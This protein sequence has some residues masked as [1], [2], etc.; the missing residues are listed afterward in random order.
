MRATAL[1]SIDAGLSTGN[2]LIA[3]ETITGGIVDVVVV[4]VGASVVVADVVGVG[5]VVVGAVVLVVGANDVVVIASSVGLQAPRRRPVM[6]MIP[7][8]TVLMPMSSG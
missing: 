6:V 8:P 2:P 4:L 3:P 1:L 5:T 7:T